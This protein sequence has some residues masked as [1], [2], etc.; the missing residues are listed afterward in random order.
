MPSLSQTSRQ[1]AGDTWSPYHWCTSSWAITC[2]D[3]T[4]SLLPRVTIVWVSIALIESVT[5]RPRESKG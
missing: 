4:Y 3:R 1:S 2:G 5:T